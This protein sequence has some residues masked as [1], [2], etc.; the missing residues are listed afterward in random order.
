M[1]SLAVLQKRW[2]Y[3]VSISGV[4]R[5]K[6]VEVILNRTLIQQKMTVI[7]RVFCVEFNP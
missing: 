7:V 6:R 2:R 4:T 3:G 5:Q 1:K